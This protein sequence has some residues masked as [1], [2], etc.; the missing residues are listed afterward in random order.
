MSFS[1]G[2]TIEADKL[3]LLSSLVSTHLG[4]A[5]P[6]G[7][8]MITSKKTRDVAIKRLLNVIT[9]QAPQSLIDAATTMHKILIGDDPVSEDAFTAAQNM[10][11]DA[12]AEGPGTIDLQ[13]DFLGVLHGDN[14]QVTRHCWRNVGAALRHRMSDL[15]RPLTDAD[16]PVGHPA[17]LFAKAYW[18][19]IEKWSAGSAQRAQRPRGFWTSRA[20]QLA[21]IIKVAEKHPGKPITH[22]LLHE[23]GLHRLA[24]MTSAS[25]LGSLVADAGLE[26]NLSYQ[27]SARWTAE[28]VMDAYANYCRR[29][30]ITLSTTALTALGGEACSLKVYALLHFPTFGDFQKE[31]VERHPDVKLPG[32]PTAKDGTRLDS[33]SEVV[34]YNALRAAF[35][36]VRIE[37]HVVLPGERVRS[38]DFVVAGI[39]WIEVLGISRAFM[40]K[41][42]ST[43]QAKYARQW[44]AKS[45]RYMALGIDPILFE[46]NDINDHCR[47]LQRIG[48]VA[49]RLGCTPTTPMQPANKQIRAKGYWRFET[50]CEAVVQVAKNSG[51]L[52][53]YAAL[54]SAGFGHASNLLRKRG[55]RA[56]VV[57][58]LSLVDP[59]RKSSKRRPQRQ[60]KR[61][62]G[63][64]R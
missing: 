39:I 37:H 44:A 32:E 31:V 57:K 9:S 4:H 25:A 45:Q 41:T 18:G 12:I 49:E 58:T 29:A 15:Q 10:L 28:R 40:A 1:P 2:N 26:R 7:G 55:M 52:P 22:A 64:R 5:V 23:S 60:S 3:D 14:A 35:P 33:W 17:P 20:N 38:A 51:K 36:A 42:S 24:L 59:N 6:L 43:R 62:I 34:V 16:F 11:A 56:R 48:D 30:G 8:H 21:A 63:A 54:T 46:P 13:L 19:G 27:P 53:T 61:Q 50:L 47:L